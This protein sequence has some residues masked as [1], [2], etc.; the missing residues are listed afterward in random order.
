MIQGGYQMRRNVL[1]YFMEY[2]Q[3]DE[4]SWRWIIAVSKFH[5]SFQVQLWNCLFSVMTIDSA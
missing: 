4:I 2:I 1:G 5:M 3:G